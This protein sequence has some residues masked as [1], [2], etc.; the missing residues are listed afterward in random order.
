MI[1]YVLIEVNE[2]NLAYADMY[3]E[4]FGKTE[5]SGSFLKVSG[6]VNLETLSVNFLYF[7]IKFISLS[8]TL[9]DSF[10]HAWFH[11]LMYWSFGKYRFTKLCRS[12]KCSYILLHNIKNKITLVSIS[13]GLIRN[14]SSDRKLSSL[15]WLIQV[16]QKFKFLLETSFYHW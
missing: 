2:R 16:F 8:W 13:T 7:Y 14:S 5:I 1:W 15:G 12:S 4:Y 3:L 10:T 9:K 6:N 11:N